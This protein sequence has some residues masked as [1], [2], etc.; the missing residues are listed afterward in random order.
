MVAAFQQ[1]MQQ[2]EF[3][4]GVPFGAGLPMDTANDTMGHSMSVDS[5]ADNLLLKDK[6]E[7]G[8]LFSILK[9][10]AAEAGLDLRT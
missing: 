2:S 5:Q 1:Q 8:G 10:N 9:R 3:L 7:H 6:A 4:H